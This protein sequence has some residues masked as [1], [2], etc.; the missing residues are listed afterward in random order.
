M[1]DYQTMVTYLVKAAA[2]RGI[3]PSVALRVAKAEGLQPGTWQ[4]NVKKGG[5]REPSYGPFQLL[6][7][8]SG[9]NFPIGLGN[10]FEHKTGLDVTNPDNWAHQIDFALDHAKSY[11]WHEWYGAKAKNVGNMDGLAMK[12]SLPAEQVTALNKTPGVMR[13]AQA[14][15]AQP[16]AAAPQQQQPTP[17]AA[18]TPD[19][20][21]DGRALQP[22][23]A[24][25]MGWSNDQP[26]YL[27]AGAGPGAGPVGVGGMYGARPG[28]SLA[29]NIHS[30]A[31]TY[32]PQVP[33]WYPWAGAAMLGAEALTRRGGLGGLFNKMMGKGQTP[34][35]AATHT[36]PSAEPA[37][38][39][40]DQHLSQNKSQSPIG[41]QHLSQYQAPEP[42]VYS[43]NTPRTGRNPLMAPG[44]GDFEFQPLKPTQEAGMPSVALPRGNPFLFA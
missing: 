17:A 26:D 12:A 29:D 33:G 3:D 7:G 13:N 34:E 18:I 6:K 22:T 38:F 41:D 39:G 44:Q 4:S 10:A 40:N 8:G 37:A 1:A 31:A 15:V 16:A 24:Q 11:G 27:G 21:P 28:G 35:E 5:V 36:V 2:A 20:T 14:P 30:A 9:T 23:L 32:A 43:K 42:F 25:R 19:A